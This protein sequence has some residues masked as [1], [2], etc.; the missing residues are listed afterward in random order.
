MGEFRESQ[1]VDLA[2]RDLYGF[3]GGPFLDRDKGEGLVLGAKKCFFG[4]LT[5]HASER[6]RRGVELGSRGVELAL[7][8][9]L[10]RFGKGKS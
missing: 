10:V 5:S 2:N 8:E 9:R 4:L 6:V 7:A 3:C 1:V